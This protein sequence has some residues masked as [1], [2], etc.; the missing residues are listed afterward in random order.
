MSQ[1]EVS[2]APFLEEPA[3]RE[4]TEDQG[5]AL[6]LWVTLA[7]CH[8]TYAKAVSAKVQEY[9]LTTPQFGTLEALYHLGPLSL[10]DLAD[11]LLVTGG[12]VTYVMDRLE[13]QGLVYRY[14]QPDDRRV[15]QA[16]LTTEG[17]N[18]VSE[19]FPGHVA[20]VENLSRHLSVEEQES[21]Q[22]LLKTLGKGIQ[23]T[24]L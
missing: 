19:V 17:R 11:K 7:R 23:E 21:L 14:R 9:G 8:A 12:N 24:D 16:R 4:W 6:G 1:T 18:L 22:A 15:V 10:G 3:S 13:D 5:V 20:Y 2:R